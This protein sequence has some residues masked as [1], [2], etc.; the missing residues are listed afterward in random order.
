MQR[1][2]AKFKVHTIFFRDSDSVMCISAIKYMCTRA[3]L[4]NSEGWNFWIWQVF[5]AS[6]YFWIPWIINEN[7]VVNQK[8]S[9]NLKEYLRN[10]QGIFWNSVNILE[11][12]WIFWKFSES[13]KNSLSYSD[14]HEEVIYFMPP[15]RANLCY[16]SYSRQCILCLLLNAIY[17]MPCTCDN[18]F[19]APYLRTW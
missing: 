1:K 16:A 11:I 14:A 13:W 15:T 6:K 3:F 7:L 19:Y 4:W 8:Y 17:V 2:L 12:Q 10:I 9:V 18:V 5:S